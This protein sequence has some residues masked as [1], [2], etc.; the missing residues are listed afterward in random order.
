MKVKKVL[1]GLRQQFA[2]DEINIIS[3]TRVIYSGTVQG[4]V[5]TDVDMIL[6]KKQIENLEVID[7]M[8][9]NGRKA[10]LFVPEIGDY[11]PAKED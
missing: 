1:A 11:Y 8:M 7:R 9:F 10:F 5:A 3:P 4:W 6:Y 2:L